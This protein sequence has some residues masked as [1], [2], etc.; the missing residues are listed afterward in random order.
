MIYG[1]FPG[2]IVES[3]PN[4]P[5]GWHDG[6]TC[7]VDLDLGFGIFFNAVDWDGHRRL[8]CRIWGINAPELSTPEGPAAL[9]YAQGL[10]PAGSR[11]SVISHDWDKYGGRFDGSLTLVGGQD[12][13]SLMLAAGQAV[14]I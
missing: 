7:L 10:A 2:R 12:F 11:V 5:L 13:A 8:S 3:L 14:K 6:D 9:A 1:P 4:Y